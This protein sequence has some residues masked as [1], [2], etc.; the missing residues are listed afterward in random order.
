MDQPFS[1]YVKALFEEQV[2]PDLTKYPTLWQGIVNPQKFPDAYLPPY[3]MAGWTL[4]YQMG[5][6]VFA[7]NSPLEARISPVEEAV[8]LEE[9]WEGSRVCLSDI[10]QNK[11][12]LHSGYRILEKGG[13]VD[14]ARESFSVGGKSYPPGTFVVIS[15]SVSK[16]FIDSLAGELSLSIGGTGDRVRSTYSLRTPK[17][18]LQ[19]VGRQFG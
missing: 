19:A 18:P 2:Y 11:Q 1:L 8:S 5:V 16:S 14:R 7:A 3:D 10:S 12:R 17:L 6:K 4:P 9:R 13:Q 15:S